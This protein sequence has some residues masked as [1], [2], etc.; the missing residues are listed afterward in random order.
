MAENT[1]SGE[2]LNSQALPKVDTSSDASVDKARAHGYPYMRDMGT[3]VPLEEVEQRLIIQEPIFDAKNGEKT[4]EVNYMTQVSELMK[5]VTDAKGADTVEQDINKLN[6]LEERVRYFGDYVKKKDPLFDLTKRYKHQNLLLMAIEAKRAQIMQG[7]NEAG[8]KTL[9]SK[10]TPANEDPNHRRELRSTVMHDNAI[11][12]IGGNLVDYFD[13]VDA[14]AKQGERVK[15]N[16]EQQRDMESFALVAD[17]LMEVADPSLGK[18]TDGK[19][20]TYREVLASLQKDT[21]ANPETNKKLREIRREFYRK[22][23]DSIKK[24]GYPLTPGEVPVTDNEKV[25]REMRLRIN[26]MNQIFRNP[27]RKASVDKLVGDYKGVGGVSERTKTKLRE[28]LTNESTG[29][30]ITDRALKGG[31]LM[32]RRTELVQEP[33]P[34]EKYDVPKIIYYKETIEAPQTLTE[35]VQGIFEPK[36]EPKQEPVP[37]QPRPE[38]DRPAVPVVQPERVKTTEPQHIVPQ[39]QPE[40]Q[41]EPAPVILDQKPDLLPEAKPQPDEKLPPAPAPEQKSEP[42]KRLDQL[43]EPAPKPEQEKPA[44][45]PVAPLAEE[46]APGPKYKDGI[47]IAAASTTNRLSDQIQA[48]ARHIRAEEAA[49]GS[50]WRYITRFLPRAIQNRILRSVFEG[51]EMRFAA[52]VD[53]AAKQALGMR[54]SVPLALDIEFALKAIQE[55][56]KRLN[57]QPWYKKWPKKLAYIPLG[58]ISGTTGLIQSPEQWEARG[59]IRHSAEAKEA[60]NEALSKSI[61]EQDNLG[62]RYAL[63]QGSFK[64]IT[65][66]N[67]QQWNEDALSTIKGETRELYTLPAEIQKRIKD[68]IEVYVNAPFSTDEEKMQAKMSLISDINGILSGSVLDDSSIVHDGKQRD[69]YRNSELASNILSVAEDIKA[70]KSYYLTRGEDGKRKL[71]SLEMRFMAGNAWW[72]KA[73]EA[74][75][76]GLFGKSINERLA[77]KLARRNYRWDRPGHHAINAVT[78]FIKDAGVF[79]TVWGAGVALSGLDITMSGSRMIL[80]ATPLGLVGGALGVATL[81]AAK[82]SGAVL[83]IR[84]KLYGI[85]GNYLQEYVQYS[86][87]SAIGRENPAHARIRNEMDRIAVKRLSADQWISEVKTLVE[88]PGIGSDE[89]KWN[90]LIGK[91]VDAKGRMRLTDLTSK[92]EGIKLATVQN[93]IQYNEGSENEQAYQMHALYSQAMAKLIA[94]NKNPRMNVAKRVKNLS[95]VR[96]AQ[97]QMGDNIQA[98]IR[99]VSADSGTPLLHSEIRD[100]NS[101]LEKQGFKVTRNESLDEKARVL[102]MLSYKKAGKAFVATAVTA[103]ALGLAAPVVAPVIGGAVEGARNVIGYV[104]EHYDEVPGNVV[105][106]LRNAPESIR[107]FSRDATTDFGQ[108]LDQWRSILSPGQRTPHLPVYER[109]DGSLTTDMNFIQRGVLRTRE[110]LIPDEPGSARVVDIAGTKVSLPEEFQYFDNGARQAII[111]TRNGEIM[112]LTGGKPLVPSEVET[113]FR[114]VTMGDAEA[115]STI[116]TTDTKLV[117]ELSIVPESPAV[118]G[119]KYYNSFKIN[120]YEVNT[121]IPVGTQWETHEEGGKVVADLVIPASDTSPRV[122]LIEDASFDSSGKFVGTEVAGVDMVSTGG[123]TAVESRV[124]GSIETKIFEGGEAMKAWK[125]MSTSIE[126]GERW[127]TNNTPRSEGSEL[128]LFNSV[129]TVK[130][131]AGRELRAVTLDANGVGWAQLGDVKVNATDIALRD[132]NIYFTFRLPDHFDEPIIIHSDHGILKLDPTSN[133]PLYGLNGKEIMIGDHKVTVGEFSNMILNQKALADIPPGSLA[134][135]YTNRLNVFNLKFISSGFLGEDGSIN[136]LN[137]IRGAGDVESVSIL[138]TGS[139]TVVTEGKPSIYEV[140]VGEAGTAP[141]PTTPPPTATVRLIPGV[142]PSVFTPEGWFTGDLNLAFTPIP[143]YARQNIER[144]VKAGEGKTEAQVKEEEK[145]EKEKKEKEKQSKVKVPEKKDHDEEEKEPSKE[146]KT[147]ATA[148]VPHNGT[149]AT[150]TNAANQTAKTPADHDTPKQDKP[151]TTTPAQGSATGVDSRVTSAAEAHN[152]TPDATITTEAEDD[153][154]VDA[155]QAAKPLA[156]QQAEMD[157]RMAEIKAQQEAEAAKARGSGNQQTAQATAQAAASGGEKK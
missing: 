2:G 130:D 128:R 113:H 82:E 138:T 46:P 43:P 111:D 64:D 22:V 126:Q 12:E 95:L 154:V 153:A 86:H 32:Y 141:V 131:A 75:A 72:G 78:N 117:P 26:E 87:E 99:E 142:F 106:A 47:V 147:A 140:T 110:Y 114:A 53:K 122:I 77:R 66:T 96:S 83:P 81:N 145:I 63:Q 143:L 45:I 100:L 127:W 88:D 146:E 74:E 80:K 57:S 33:T 55:G 36:E 44:E 29:M 28:L 136:Q 8:G 101:F 133:A 125:D 135:E 148:T 42:E 120:D 59:W 5:K 98:I 144:S 19:T 60:L 27:N 14:N 92:R 121:Y 69:N 91:I 94:T 137:T 16:P 156:D 107:D 112:D 129:E 85:G 79:S 18:G 50:P 51:R 124:A 65:P 109:P 68:K 9:R 48:Q 103:G 40:T 38:P 149:P 30:S 21:A 102:A 10:A 23:I 105:T 123:T 151:Q 34:E 157:R 118:S 49:K 37:Q 6:Q 3:G 97:L 54:E 150:P 134:S 7:A 139:D 24:S 70:N 116:P 17:K 4:V 152:T 104:G 132:N 15:A 1:G 39:V 90:A 155:V 71:D 89:A 108:E 25:L 62:N 84:G 67:I 31:E 76:T 13:T 20:L 73:R 11:S 119:D 41:P 93:F 52:D 61:V 35:L 58:F 56:K 115:A